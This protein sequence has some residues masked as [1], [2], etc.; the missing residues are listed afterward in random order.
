WARRRR[1]FALV[2]KF[3]ERL[4]DLGSMT[5]H[6]WNREYCMDTLGSQS[7]RSFTEQDLRGWLQ[8]LAQRTIANAGSPTFTSRMLADSAARPDLT[9]GDIFGRMS[10]LIDGS[11]VSVT[12]RGFQPTASTIAHALGLA[13]LHHLDGHLSPAQ[14]GA[15][16]TGW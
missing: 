2:V 9:P 3:R 5:P 6:R 1:L 4:S 15:A 14:A 11:F 8:D 13:L 10:D 7:G 12:E 16:L